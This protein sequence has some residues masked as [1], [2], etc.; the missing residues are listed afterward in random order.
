MLRW[1]F[2]VQIQPK[3]A[4]KR[5]NAEKC[6]KKLSHTWV[7]TRI[8]VLYDKDSTHL[9]K[10]KHAKFCFF[11][12]YSQLLTWHHLPRSSVPAQTYPY[13]TYSLEN[14]HP[15]AMM[16]NK[17]CVK[18]DRGDIQHF[19]DVMNDAL[20][21]LSGYMP[22]C[23]TNLLLLAHTSFVWNSMENFLTFRMQNM[24]QIF[25]NHLPCGT[26]WY[27]VCEKKSSIE[28]SN[29]GQI[30]DQLA[31]QLQ[32]RLSGTPTLLLLSTNHFTGGT[33]VPHT[34]LDI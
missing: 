28:K 26:G 10:S 27:P 7:L 2:F 9:I 11:L 32:S 1:D 19:R 30:S 22:D 5:I 25:R 34:D 4:S 29:G 13:S 20:G 14:F 31:N 23:N 33:R 18:P 3:R 24:F 8:S 15:R 21:Y 17:Y 12:L 16:K 6:K